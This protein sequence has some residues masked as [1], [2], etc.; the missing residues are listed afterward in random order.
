MKKCPL[1]AEEIQ[2]EAIKCR[3]C[4]EMLTEAPRAQQRAKILDQAPGERTVEV[5]PSREV[6][7]DPATGNEWVERTNRLGIWLGAVAVAA[8]IGIAGLSLMEPSG[9]DTP[10]ET[11]VTSAKSSSGERASPVADE[12]AKAEL[13]STEWVRDSYVSPGHMNVGVIPGEKDWNAPMIGKW[14]CGVLA[15]NGSTL[16]W[17]RFVDIQAVASEGK[18]PRQAEISIYRCR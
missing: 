6:W 1:C 16:T 3:Y 2:D 9:T 13:L 8:L 11:G 7:G 15:K 17:I 4:G 12:A 18:S 5:E 14:A 10:R